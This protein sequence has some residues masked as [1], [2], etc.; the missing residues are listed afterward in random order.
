MGKAV[1]LDEG[2][3]WLRNLSGAE[4]LALTAQMTNGVGRGDRG[5]D[6]VLR[7]GSSAD[8]MAPGRDTKPFAH[9]KY[10]VAFILIGDP[11]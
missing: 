5:K 10:W 9:P 7:V 2:K 4:A 11:N 8:P 3:R 1:A 6:V